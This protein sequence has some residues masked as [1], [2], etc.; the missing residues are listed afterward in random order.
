MGRKIKSE[1]LFS[2]VS[3]GGVTAKW[4]LFSTKGP[5][6]LVLILSPALVPSIRSG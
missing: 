4:L 6:K 5:V 1:N 3:P 2:S